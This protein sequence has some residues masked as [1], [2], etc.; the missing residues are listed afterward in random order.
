[1][2]GRTVWAMPPVVLPQ[3]MTSSIFFSGLLRRGIAGFTVGNGGV[4]RVLHDMGREADLT[5]IGD[6]VVAVLSFIC[7]YSVSSFR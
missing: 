6:K 1:M 7:G 3:P 5:Q 4:A 2:P